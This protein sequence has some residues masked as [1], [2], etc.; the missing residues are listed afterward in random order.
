MVPLQVIHA[1]NPRKVSI[2]L[3]K[4]V[5]RE[6]PAVAGDRFG[7]RPTCYDKTQVIFRKVFV[8]DRDILNASQCDRKKTGGVEGKKGWTR[9]HS[10]RPKCGRRPI[11]CSTHHVAVAIDDQA[12]KC[13]ECDVAKGSRG[14]SESG[15]LA[16]RDGPS[17]RTPGDGTNAVLDIHD[18]QFNHILYTLL[19]DVIMAC[20]KA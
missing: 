11:V 9:A 7:R 17:E 6:P 20:V 12:S 10:D 14:K 13:E 8:N 2:V 3:D 16:N 1:E 5:S 4:S 19:P 18:L 15:L